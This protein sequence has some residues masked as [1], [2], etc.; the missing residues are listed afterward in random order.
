M[1]TTKVNRMLYL[2]M[3]SK[4]KYK[5]EPLTDSN[6]SVGTRITHFRKARCYTQNELANK[7]GI[8]RKLVAD[9]ETGRVRLFDEMLARF[10]LALKVSA[11]ELL[12]LKKNDFV[13]AIPS[14][15][16]M[17]RFQEIE[18]LPALKKKAILK[19]IDDLIRANS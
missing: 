9:Y 16:V 8:S 4:P 2:F 1:I 14:L 19:T 7:I 11:D 6:E 13:E 15:R 12:G 5:L 3:P 17:R 18:R 10:A